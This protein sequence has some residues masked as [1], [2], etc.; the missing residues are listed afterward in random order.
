VFP[1]EQVH[2]DLIVR[3]RAGTMSRHRTGRSLAEA[4]R[5]EMDAWESG[6]R[7]PDNIFDRLGQASL[8]SVLAKGI[9]AGR[10]G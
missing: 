6:A 2:L 3:A 4:I 9:E 5:S 8:V 7:D 1:P 10:S